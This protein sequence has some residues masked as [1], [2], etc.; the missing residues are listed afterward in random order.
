VTSRVVSNGPTSVRKSNNLERSRTEDQL[1]AV[2]STGMIN[3]HES[4]GIW[5]TQSNLSPIACSAGAQPSE[6]TPGRYPE[7]QE[8]VV[9]ADMYGTGESTRYDGEILVDDKLLASE[10]SE[11]A[12][13][14]VIFWDAYGRIEAGLDMNETALQYTYDR[15]EM[16]FIRSIEGEPANATISWMW[17][18][19]VNDVVEDTNTTETAT[20]FTEDGVL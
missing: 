14:G 4:G 15:S 1:T 6:G 2:R 3:I 8:S 18:E 7:T 20:E 12:T 19:S 10:I 13:Q 16:A 9:F 17:D 5:S 11:E